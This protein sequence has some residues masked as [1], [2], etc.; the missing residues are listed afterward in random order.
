MSESSE[1]VKFKLKYVGK[2]FSKARLPVEV[3]GDFQAFRDLLVDQIKEKWFTAHP[4]RVRLPRGFDSSL[5]FV[6]ADVE[7]GSAQ[8]VFELDTQ[9]SQAM[10]PEL[11]EELDSLIQSSFHDLAKTLGGTGTPSLSK[12]QLSRLNKFGSGLLS[13]EKIVFVVE[14]GTDSSNED[15]FF[16][17]IDRRKKILTPTQTSTYLKRCRGTAEISGSKVSTNGGQGELYVFSE[18]FGNLAIPV[19]N[20]VILN[21]FES[22]TGYEVEF[23]FLAEL[24]GTDTVKKIRETYDLSLVEEYADETVSCLVDRIRSLI[25]LKAGWLSENEGLPIEKTSRLMAERFVKSRDLLAKYSHV[26]PT[27]GGGVTVEISHTVWDLTVEFS[28][29]QIYLYGVRQDG[30]E[31]LQTMIFDSLDESFYQILDARVGHGSR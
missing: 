20:D 19:E 10:L 21:R 14:Q 12:I 18:D 22:V 26:F 9:S 2:R 25:N 29:G 11:K 3:L 13:G 1:T 7:D 8:P 16:L 4:D 17:D 31:I 24:D 27:E 23:E 28:S 5:N 6:L 30:S 15:Y